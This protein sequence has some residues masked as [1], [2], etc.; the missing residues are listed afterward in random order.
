MGSEM[1]IRDS[2]GS[3]HER[4]PIY[5]NSS[6]EGVFT[7]WWTIR[8]FTSAS[9]NLQNIGKFDFGISLANMQGYDK[10]RLSKRSTQSRCLEFCHSPAY[11]QAIYVHVPTLPII[12]FLLA[13]VP[14]SVKQV[15]SMTSVRSL[16]I[17][18]LRGAA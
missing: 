12:R 4:L 6:V 7:R 16:D 1:C 11:L 2:N 8:A 17:R 14:D 15:R 5:S 13:C 9:S 18:A 3:G 10:T